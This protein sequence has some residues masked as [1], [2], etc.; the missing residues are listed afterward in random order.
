MFQQVVKKSGKKGTA[1]EYEA[2]DKDS[3][4]GNEGRR[5]SLATWIFSSIGLSVGHQLYLWS[6][7]SPGITHRDFYD[8]R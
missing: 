5:M 8:I 6:A 3:A 2:I 4:P 1:R 7:L